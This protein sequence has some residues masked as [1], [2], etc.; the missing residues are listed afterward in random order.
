MTRPP[1]LALKKDLTR[2]LRQGHPWVFREAIL[3]QPGLAPGALVA[4]ADKQGRTV[5]FGYWD[6]RSP[7]A[8]RVLDLAS[9]EDKTALIRHR[10]QAALAMRRARLDLNATNAFRWVHGEADR[11]PG[12]HV[13]VYG[14]VATVRY[15]GEGARAFFADLPDLLRAC[16]GNW[17]LRKIIDREARS[18]ESEEIEVREHGIRFLVDV[19]R[20]Q[21]GG[22][23]LDQRQNRLAVAK[24]AH[25][26]SVLNLFGYTGGFSLHA[27]KAGAWRTDTVDIARP[28]IA[29]AQR[30]FEINSF[31]LSRAGF[32]AIDVFAFLD[33][34][35]KKGDRWDIVIS[36]PPSFAPSKNSV[37]AA[38]RSYLRLHRLAASVVSTNG[39]LCA[40]SCSSHLRRDEFL[41]LVKTGVH[42]AGRRFFLE[43]YAGAGLDHPTL[44]VFPE[45]DYLKCAFGK[46]Q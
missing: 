1:I 43:W 12:I 6:A 31:D 37:E 36:D 17:P 16:A 46:V 7:I 22:L 41:T 24:V 20:G 34:A 44:P 33:A 29:A 40:A 8:V 26:K 30:N 9:V 3:P 19:G 13:D 11:L 10:L 2:A 35:I 38:K 27:A 25:G 18:D 39:M 14:D 45:G 15:D 28:A 32:H 5:A 21:K 4:V 23:F 42:Q